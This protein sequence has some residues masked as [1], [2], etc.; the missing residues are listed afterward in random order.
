[1][2]DVAIPAFRRFQPGLILVACGYDASGLDPLGRM[3][4]RSHSYRKLAR[5]LLDAARDINGGAVVFCHEGGY[6]EAYVPF[7]GLAAIEGLLEVRTD[8]ADP[9]FPPERQI[10]G[11][12]LRT[13]QATVVQHGTGVV[14]DVRDGRFSA[15][16]GAIR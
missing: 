2:N 13:D 3:L 15:P 7:R 16:R 10:A 11:A 14:S 8:V 12:G 4:L 6:S 5:A 9:Y 1:M